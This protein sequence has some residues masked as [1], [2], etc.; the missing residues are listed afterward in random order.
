VILNPFALA[1]LLSSVLVDFL[2][3]HA[4]FLGVRIWR[5]WDLRSGSELQ[6][7]L[8]RRTYLV[9]TLLGYAL[10]FQLASLFLFIHAA[11]A[12]APFFTGAMCAA[13]TLNA[14]AY[15]YPALLFKICN[16]LL[17]GAWL[18]LNRA[19][20]MAPDYPL[21]RVKYGLLLAMAPFLLAESAAVF[22]HFLG[23][24][25]GVITSCCGSR[26]GAGAKG[27]VSEVASIPPGPSMAAF[28]TCLAALLGCGDFFL[29][30]K[31]GAV[32]LAIA[33]AATAV[34]SA[35]ALVSALC[36]YVYE[37]PS[38]H[39]PFCLLQGEYGYVGYPLY[40]TLLGGCISGSGVGILSLFRRIPSL[41]EAVP[42]FQEVLARCALLC[43][44]LFGAIAS[45]PVVFS[46]FRM[47]RG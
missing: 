6:L 40:L 7:L 2:V 16:F 5:H 31:R 35:A 46:D 1:L 27:V 32:A 26:F 24:E 23:M 43:Y 42:G 4:T 47:F 44:A 41:A 3:L 12:F 11:D 38:H 36:L 13:G 45:Y 39:C 9:S 20:N 18:L 28:Y 33:S 34:V 37:L 15:G 29:R 25:P 14:T 17:A 30:K 21:I 22:L 8:E 19:D 10:A